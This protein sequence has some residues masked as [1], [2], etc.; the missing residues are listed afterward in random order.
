MFS[1]EV[2]TCIFQ[3]LSQHEHASKHNLQKLEKL[4]SWKELHIEIAIQVLRITESFEEM[5]NLA[6]ETCSIFCD[7]FHLG[8]IHSV[9]TQNFPKN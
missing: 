3:T 9:R 5:K 1:T 6:G 4:S 2:Y 7:D 8:I